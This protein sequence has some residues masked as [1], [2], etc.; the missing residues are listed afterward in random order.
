M[1]QQIAK[2]LL[3]DEEQVNVGDDRLT[4]IVQKLKKNSIYD[5][6]FE[7]EGVSVKTPGTMSGLLSTYSEEFITVQVIIT[8]TNTVN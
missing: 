6:T 3:P 1:H 2:K 8:L 4:V 5:K 7:A